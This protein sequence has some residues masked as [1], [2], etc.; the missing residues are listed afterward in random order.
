MLFL[1]YIRILR[2]LQSEA[3]NEIFRTNK[4]NWG[5]RWIETSRDMFQRAGKPIYKYLMLSK[6]IERLSEEIAI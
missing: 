6:L 3:D 4:N 5:K 2:N 1:D